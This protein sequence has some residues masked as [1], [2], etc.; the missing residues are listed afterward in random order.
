M[1][2]TVGSKKVGKL[3]VGKFFGIGIGIGIGKI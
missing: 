1:K 2:V 3:Q